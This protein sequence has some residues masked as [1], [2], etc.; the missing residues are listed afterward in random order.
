VTSIFLSV[1]QNTCQDFSCDV[2]VP[3]INSLCHLLR[4][5]PECVLVFYAE[6]EGIVVYRSKGGQEQKAFDTLEWLVAMCSHVPD[7]GKQMVRY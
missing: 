5:N 1:T 6:E 7:K 2:L 4:P 3:I